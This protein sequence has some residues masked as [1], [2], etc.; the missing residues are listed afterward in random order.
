MTRVCDFDSEFL[1]W[2]STWVRFKYVCDS[3]YNR[4]YA[5]FCKNR[6]FQHASCTCSTRLSD[7]FAICWINNYFRFL[8]N[9]T[10]DIAI[11]SYNKS[12]LLIHSEKNHSK[13]TINSQ[14]VLQIRL[15]Y[16]KVLEKQYDVVVPI[17]YVPLQKN[18][19]NLNY[20]SASNSRHVDLTYW[21]NH[22]ARLS[23]PN[24]KALSTWT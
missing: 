22:C 12:H 21:E 19:P 24:Q 17:L 1:T 3:W 4:T 18:S 5:I 11:I 8:M 10:S 16:T 2:I 7:Y 23:V 15:L 14:W 9:A 20:I 6:F 13:F